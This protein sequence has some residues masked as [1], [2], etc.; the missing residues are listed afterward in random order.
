MSNRIGRLLGMGLIGV[1]LAMSAPA[2]QAG[3]GQ[4]YLHGAT[5]KLGR[6]VCN[7]ITCPLELL[8]VPD[9][10]G[11]SD[12][13][14]AASTVGLARGLVHGVLRGLAGVIEVV[15]FPIEVPNDFGPIV[16]P[17]YVWTEGDWSE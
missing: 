5:R 6:G 10:V 17:E 13:Y 16:K 1:W 12:G 14:L 8:R 2:A 11:R 7:I 3:E 4:S 9:L 15:T